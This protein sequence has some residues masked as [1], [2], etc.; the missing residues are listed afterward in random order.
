MR[1]FSAVLILTYCTAGGGERFFLALFVLAGVSDLLDGIVARKLNVCSEFGSKL[2]SISDM[3]L[4]VATLL[5]LC[6][7]A[8][9][10]LRPCAPFA[11]VGFATQAF[12]IGYAYVKL[13]AYPAYH[14]KLS[15]LMAYAIFFSVGGFW[16]WKTAALLPFI[17][18]I[19]TTCSLEGIAITSILRR[20]MTN[21]SGIGN[22]LEVTRT[23]EGLHNA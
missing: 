3:A 18:I 5:F 2:D 1:L 10:Y 4:Y 21:V 11:L 7:H 13:G 17:A 20:A 6:T 8:S 9:S 19:W 14:S 15:R 22:A 12:H 16:I 23:R